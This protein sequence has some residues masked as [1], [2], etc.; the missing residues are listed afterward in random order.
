MEM[1]REDGT[2]LVL[3]FPVDVNENRAEGC[4]THTL[5]RAVGET[6]RN[7]VLKSGAK[8]DTGEEPERNGLPPQRGES[9]PHT[10]GHICTPDEQTG[11]FGEI[12]ADA[13]DAGVPEPDLWTRNTYVTET[14]SGYRTT[15]SGARGTDSCAVAGDAEGDCEI[16][17]NLPASSTINM[18]NG[19]DEDVWEFQHSPAVVGET[20]SN[21]ATFGPGTPWA[22][23][24][25]EETPSVRGSIA[26]PQET[27]N[28]RGNNV[29]NPTASEETPDT[30]RSN[31]HLIVAE[32][33]MNIGGTSGDLSAFGDSDGTRSQI[34]T[35]PRITDNMVENEGICARLSTSG[36]PAACRRNNSKTIVIA[37]TPGMCEPSTSTNVADDLLGVG[38]TSAR[39]STSGEMV[40][41]TRTSASTEEMSGT[42]DNTARLSVSEGT[43]STGGNQG[44]LATSGATA[45]TVKS[46]PGPVE[47]GIGDSLTTYGNKSM[48]YA[49]SAAA[50]TG[51]PVGMKESGVSKIV[52]GPMDTL[53]LVDGVSPQ[54][55]VA[56]NP[57]LVNHAKNAEFA[58]WENPDHWLYP[59]VCGRK[60]RRSSST[61]LEMKI[62]NG[63]VNCGELQTDK[64][65]SE[66]AI[67]DKGVRVGN[68]GY[69][70]INRRSITGTSSIPV[71]SAREPWNSTEQQQEVRRSTSDLGPETTSKLSDELSNQESETRH[72]DDVGFSGGVGA[73][74]PRTLRTNPGQGVSLSCDSTPLSDD[75][76]AYFV[77]DGD[78]DVIM[79]S[80]EL[81]RTQSVPDKLQ[82]SECSDPESSAEQT[83][84]KRH[85]FTDFLTR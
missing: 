82:E 75:S 9:K 18:S 57:Q 85:A 30:W 5:L 1:D 58:I 3:S 56:G 8:Q 20:S 21:Q 65:R 39:F 43:V 6:Q 45:G 76:T 35:S 71:Y 10:S 60:C 37:V 79:N 77:D 51:D 48:L 4:K 70:V 73:A 64:T 84:N 59:G 16:N 7:R 44:N 62:P 69:L 29:M 24:D 46:I 33:A 2:E 42:C 14:S 72:G 67:R 47:A 61:E 32:E 17:G 55:Q 54:D 25:L 38:G 68:C 50:V 22:P 41:S 19:E 28:I 81:G 23:A 52:A 12:T 31:K 15:S 53:P 40:G 49:K 83:V 63:G 80:L 66:G 27:V 13:S 74:R 11:C 36:K 26:V 34:V 78:M